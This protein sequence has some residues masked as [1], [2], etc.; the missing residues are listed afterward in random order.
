[1]SVRLTVC[2]TCKL[3]PDR[4]YDARGRT[5]GELLAAALEDA[6][7]S[8]GAAVTLSRHECLWACR[9]HCAV[10]IESAGRTGYLAGR[11]VP[12]DRAAAAILEWCAAYAGTADGE[13]PF[14]RWPEAIKGHFIARLP[15]ADR[16]DA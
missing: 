13:V 15:R 7:A 16:E 4:A 1:M 10:L 2:V 8:R 12:G 5:G 3:A 9:D 6:A 14:A 11:F